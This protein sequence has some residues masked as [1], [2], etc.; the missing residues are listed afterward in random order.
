MPAFGDHASSALLPGDELALRRHRDNEQKR[1]ARP[2]QTGTLR[3]SQRLQVYIYNAGPFTRRIDTLGSLGVVVIPGLPEKDVLKDLNVAGPVIRAGLPAEPY[4]GEP[5][6]QWLELEPDAHALWI[7]ADGEQIRMVDR[8][9]IDEALR[10]IGGHPES[11]KNPYAASPYEQGCFVSLVPRQ[12]APPK[13]PKEPGANASAAARQTHAKAVVQYDE[14]LRLWL[15]WEASVQGAHK[16]FT[17]WAMRRGEEQSLAYANGQYVR[18]EELFVLAR[19]FGKTTKDWN[20]LAGTAT[21]ASQ[22]HCHW[23]GTFMLADKAKCPNCKEWQ[24]G[25]KPTESA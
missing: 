8:P 4:P 3:E 6:G 14:D 11:Q 25:M 12:I 1:M 18:D 19:I 16:R 15:K 10:I 24:P 7:D 22:K 13:E 2:R 17:E 9:G 23:C 5:R 20:F 21:N